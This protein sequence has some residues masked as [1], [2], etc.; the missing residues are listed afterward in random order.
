MRHN[1][2]LCKGQLFKEPLYVLKDM[3]EVSQNLPT[4]ETLSLDKTMDLRLCQCSK[5]GLVQFDCEPVDY[6]KDS[7]RA[8]ERSEGLVKL[9]RE[10]YKYLIETYNLQGKKILEIGAG[11]GGYLKTLKEMDEYKIQEYGIENN[12]D[13]VRIAN[14]KEGVKVFHGNPEDGDLNIPGA[15]FDAFVSFSYPARLINPN[16]M[17]ELVERNLSEDGIG[18]VMVPSLE[19]LLKQDGFF[20]VARDLIAYYSI[21]TLKFLFQKNNFEIMECGE[22]LQYYIYVVV[23]KRKAINLKSYW[24]NADLLI[25]EMKNV[26]NRHIAVGKK[27]A[28]WCAGHFAFTVLSTSG[29]GKEISYIIDNADFKKGHFAPGSKVLIVGPEHFKD[30]PVDTIMILGPI[31]VDEIVKEIR[32]KC[33]DKVRIM[34]VNQAGIQEIEKGC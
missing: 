11:K 34:T 28:V 16:G 33:S 1:C 22:K 12:S 2:I 18:Y 31:Y 4:L 6:Y 13:Y 30:E 8:A 5:C 27:I 3:P 17:I 24:S 15:P 26:T 20:D 10:D 21:E 23:K 32:E 25:K 19:H 29:I 7:T 9:R 14:E